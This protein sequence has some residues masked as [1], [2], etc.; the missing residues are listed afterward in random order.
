[1]TVARDCSVWFRMDSANNL[2]TV[3]TCAFCPMGPKMRFA[4]RCVTT[5]PPSICGPGNTFEESG[6][7]IATRRCGSASI[8]LFHGLGVCPA[9]DRKRAG[10]MS[11][12]C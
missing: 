6:S 10:V 2:S 12:T 11:T 7:N 1:M 9:F 8:F 4:S 3:G 5:T